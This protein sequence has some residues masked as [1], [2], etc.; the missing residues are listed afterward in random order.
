MGNILFLA[1]VLVDEAVMAEF[2]R[3]IN[4]FNCCSDDA[5]ISSERDAMYKKLGSIEFKPKGFRVLDIASNSFLDIDIESYIECDYNINGLDLSRDAL[6]NCGKQVRAFNNDSDC[7]IGF[8]PIICG[9]SLLEIDKTPR[10]DFRYITYASSTGFI[11]LTIKID[12]INKKYSISYDSVKIVDTI[13]KDDK[14]FSVALY[15][16]NFS[17]NISNEILA[18]YGDNLGSSFDV[19]LNIALIK[20][21]KGQ[22]VVT[23]GVTKI[24]MF[25]NTVYKDFTLVIPQT[26]KEFGVSDGEYELSLKNT[27]FYISNENKNL[28]YDIVNCYMNIYEFGIIKDRSIDDLVS[29]C[30][31]VGIYFKFY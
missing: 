16:R 15:F 21:S 3:I 23:N 10:S 30:S 2:N 4:E 1:G 26:V 7:D 20:R 18:M 8:V 11:P 28:V 5:W 27:T 19:V 12:F 13:N 25:W 31:D 22:V 24:I 14:N 17:E 6:L 9:D 29:L